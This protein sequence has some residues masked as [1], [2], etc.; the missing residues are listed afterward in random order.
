M[1]DIVMM[2][3]GAAAKLLLIAAGA[4]YASLVAATYSKEGPDFQLRLEL[5]DPARSAERLLIWAG[6]RITTMMA[7]AVRWILELLYEASAD[8]GTWVVSKSNPQVQARVSSRFL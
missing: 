4:L 7:G 5:G 8:V 3:V 2:L 1:D 6:V